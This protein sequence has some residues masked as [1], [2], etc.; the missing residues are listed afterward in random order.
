MPV[1]TPPNPY[2][3]AHA[4]PAG[5][6][7]ARPTALQILKDNALIGNLKDKV[8]LGTGLT[9]GLGLQTLTQL[10]KTGARIIFTARNVA[11]AQKVV[12]DLVE[13][14][15]TD[16]DLHGARVDFVEMDNKSLA[17]V[18]AA[19]EQI[20]TKTDKLNVLIC[21]AGEYSQTPVSFHKLTSYPGISNTPYEKTTDGFEAQFAINHLAHFL[22]FQLLTPL[23][24]KSS[25]RNFNTRVIAVAS[26]AHTFSTVQ[27]GNYALDSPPKESYDPMVALTDDD[28]FTH[29]PLLLYGQSKTANIWFANEIERRYGA[30]GVHG[31]S[32]HPGNI[33]T[34]LW[35]NVDPRVTAKLGPLIESMPELGASFKS[36]EQGAATQ[37]LA[38]VGNDWEG[39]GGVYLDDCGASEPI[40]EGAI[41]G[42]SGYKP[43]AYDV[44]GAGRLWEDSLEMVKA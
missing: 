2:A 16:S 11:K 36:V 21:N 18:R 5:P 27:L 10:A 24:L 12:E 31:L 20:L 42:I 19:A 23:L 35:T 1:Q 30:Q 40:P 37:V 32:V 9:D 39:V 25:T 41:T 17:S 38:A 28:D 7:D 8:I 14:S 43:W 15:K 4:S 34:A 33:V 29:N 26:V 44:E 22:L 13:A 3:A 6:G